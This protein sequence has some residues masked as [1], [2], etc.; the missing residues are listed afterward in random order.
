[1]K[2]VRIV[3]HRLLLV[4]SCT[5][6]FS[7]NQTESFLAPSS[8]SYLHHGS[9][10]NNYHKSAQIVLHLST[11]VGDSSAGY[12]RSAVPLNPKELFDN[13]LAV[14][15]E[16]YSQ[17]TTEH[18]LL[19]AFLQAACLASAADVTTQALESGAGAV[20]F[21]HVAAM[22]TVASIMS[23]FMNA[24]WLR[25]LE[26]AFPG[27]QTKEVVIKTLIHA[28]IIASIINSAYLVFVPIFTE[29]F[30]CAGG[31]AGFGFTDLPSV[32]FGKFEMDEFITLTKLELLMFVPYNTLAFKLIPPQVRPL[33]HAAVSATFN[34][35]VSAVTLGYFN[36]WCER[37]QNIFL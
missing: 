11:D 12:R 23:G 1:M 25:Q 4:A 14:L 22:A 36:I 24:V 5:L 10:L 31:G 6:L 26:G 2:S 30:F 16:G 9:D 33:T 8:S 35:A 34:V 37:A 29:Y 32:A 15:S 27:T 7:V 17:L 28:V 18:Y 21:R 3:T 20:D 19:M 13:S